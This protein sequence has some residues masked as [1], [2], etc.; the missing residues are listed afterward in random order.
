MDVGLKWDFRT[1]SELPSTL[2]RIGWWYFWFC[3]QIIW[4]IILRWVLVWFCGRIIFLFTLT[5]LRSWLRVCRTARMDL[6]ISW[7]PHCEF[8]SSVPD[9]TLS[10]WRFVMPTDFPNDG[11]K[12]LTISRSM[13]EAMTLI[14]SRATAC[15]DIFKMFPCNF[16][17]IGCIFRKRSTAELSSFIEFSCSLIFVFN[18]LI[19]SLSVSQSWVVTRNESPSSSLILLCAFCCLHLLVW[20]ATGVPL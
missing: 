14:F 3:S 18:C 4:T 8:F 6:C 17:T 7:L 15:F 16:L 11:V 1:D 5:L 12:G 2:L 10:L 19:N 9:F 20:S 13:F